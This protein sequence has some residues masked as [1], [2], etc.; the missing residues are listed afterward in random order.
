[1]NI[2]GPS[3]HVV[4]CTKELC[5]FGYETRLL[6]GM[7]NNNEGSMLH[8]AKENNISVKIIDG[9]G[10]AISPINDLKALLQIIKEIKE[11]KP[12]IIHTHT[13]KAGI[14][15]RLAALICGV[16]HIYHTYHGNVFKGYFSKLFTQSIIGI[17]RIFATFSTNIIALTPNLAEELQQLLRLKN[18]GKIKIIP[19]GLDLKRFLDKPRKSTNWR[20]SIGLT[21]EEI[22]IGIVARLVPIKNHSLLVSS[23][24]I[25]TKSFPNLHL[26]IIG[27]GEEEDNLRALTNELNL[28]E[29]IHF[30]GISNKMEDIY[31]DL[32]LLVL[33]SKNEGTPVVIIEALAAGC[34]VAA[35]NVGGVAE[36]FQNSK[37]GFLLPL[38]EKAFTNKLF[39]ILKT[40]K[41]ESVNENTRKQITE[42]YSVQKLAANLNKLYEL[43][44]RPVGKSMNS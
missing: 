34:P 21:Q 33:C 4:N 19:L 32:D 35:T 29:K 16:P 17:E 22:L 8:L 44:Q 15:G 36:L 41:N 20:E 30:C 6:S 14:L 27:M 7:P 23:M 5:N 37:S 26:A 2:G 31:S 42:Y 43:N 12:Q 1:M 18:L 28:T 10:R 9:L 3:Y 25:L 11:F 13:T 40:I 39:E 38:E 24:N